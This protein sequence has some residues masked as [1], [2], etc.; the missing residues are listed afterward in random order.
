MR[1]FLLAVTAAALLLVISVGA[2]L[3]PACRKSPHR[4]LGR[5]RCK[6]GTSVRRARPCK[7]D[8]AVGSRP[9]CTAVRAGALVSGVVISRVTA[10]PDVVHSGGLSR[11]KSFQSGPCRRSREARYRADQ[12]AMRAAVRPWTNH[13]A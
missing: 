7:V 5:R 13:A 10:F 1:A 6:R 2:L 12:T 11:T 4:H 8:L 3:L 9:G